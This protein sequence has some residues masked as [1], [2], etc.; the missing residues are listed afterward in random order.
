MSLRDWSSD[1]CSS[2]LCSVPPQGLIASQFHLMFQKPHLFSEINRVMAG[3]HTDTST[4]REALF[5]RSEERRVGKSVDLSAGASI[6]KKLR[7]YKLHT[8]RTPYIP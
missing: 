8:L 1:V 3:D 5:A 2:D 6:T 7:T 4:L